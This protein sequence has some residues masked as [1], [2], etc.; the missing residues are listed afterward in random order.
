[1]ARRVMEGNLL[2]FCSLSGQ[3]SLD[4]TVT[5]PEKALERLLPSAYERGYTFGGKKS[6]IF[7]VPCW[8][9]SFWDAC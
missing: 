3:G 4:G 2:D 6:C 5:H 7:A 8:H 1:M 9:L